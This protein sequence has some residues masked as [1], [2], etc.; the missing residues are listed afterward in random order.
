MKRLLLCFMLLPGLAFAQ[1]AVIETQDDVRTA[2]LAEMSRATPPQRVDLADRLPPP[3]NQV[4]TETCVSWAVTYAAA[5]EALHRG[6][7]ATPLIPLS[8]AFTYPLAG[9]KPWC[10]GTTKLSRTLD[11]LRDVGALPI[12]E[13]SFD[14]GW[15]G[16]EP[17]A[18]ER[19][20][21]AR[22]RIPGWRRLDAADLNAVKG[23][24]AGGRPVVFAMQIGPAFREYRGDTVFN[25]IET[26]PDLAGHAMI[27][28]G[29]DEA[30]GAFR[31]MNSFGTGWGD[32]GYAWLSFLV[33]RARMEPGSVAFVIE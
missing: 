6:H 24:L 23:K 17:S 22:F 8:P 14:A 5:S 29:Y 20:R 30:R 28:T 18:A 7:T 21:A 25:R 1:G 19:T 9:G 12:E 31:L 4:G 15:C 16:R 3:R 32:H 10:K 26:G 13:Y 11:V 2:P 33:W 27:L